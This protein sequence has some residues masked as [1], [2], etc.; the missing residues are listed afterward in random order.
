M[1]APPREK[2]GIRIE[3]NCNDQLFLG[4]GCGNV[5]LLSRAKGFVYGIISKEIVRRENAT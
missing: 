2:G 5:A 1:S 3:G 4:T